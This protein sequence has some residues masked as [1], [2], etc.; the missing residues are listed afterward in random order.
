MGAIVS[1]Q[2][3]LRLPPGT[4][5]RLRALARAAGAFVKRKYGEVGFVF[6]S[7]EA[8]RA[9]N[10]AYRRH[11]KVTDVLSFTYSAKPVS[12]EVVVCLAQ[13]ARQAKRRRHELKR[14]LD[15]LAVHGLLHLAGYDHMKHAERARMRALERKVLASLG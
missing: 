14:E 5:A 2:L 13:A 8:I 7:E 11:D 4:A 6:V 15:I 10:R 3:A 9:L 1:N 12:G